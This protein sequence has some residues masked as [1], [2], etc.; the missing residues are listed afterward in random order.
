MFRRVACI[1][2]ASGAV[3]WAQLAEEVPSTPAVEDVFVRDSAAAMDRLALAARMERL[4]EWTTS[5]QVYQ[6]LIEQHGPTLLP[7][8]VDERTRPLIYRSVTREVQRRLAAWPAEGIEVYRSLYGIAAAGALETA[9]SSPSLLARVLDHYFVTDAGLDAGLRLLESAYA[10]GEFVNAAMLG[11]R[12]L[13]HPNLGDRRSMLR[14]RTAATWALAG[15]PERARAQATQLAAESPD[16]SGVVGGERQNLVRW[17]DATLPALDAGLSTPESSWPTAFGSATRSAIGFDAL[18]PDASQAIQ[19]ARLFVAPAVRPSGASASADPN[20]PTAFSSTPGIFPVIEGNELYFQDNHA[21]YAWDLS[22]GQPLPRWLAER[23]GSGDGAQRFGSGEPPRSTPLTLTLTSDA[24]LAVLGQIDPLTGAPNRVTSASASLVCLNRADGTVRWRFSTSDLREG[25]EALRFTAPVGTPMV[26]GDSV[27][28]VTRGGRTRQFDDTFLVCLDAID[29]T[30][31]WSRHLVSGSGSSSLF[32]LTGTPSSAVG[33]QAALADGRVFVTTDL[34]AVAAVD[35]LDGNIAWLSVY[36]RPKPTGS[37]FVRR[38]FGETQRAASSFGTN[39][40]IHSQG[41]I[42]CIPADTRSLFVFDAVDGTRIQDLDL[43]RIDS[44]GSG[45]MLVGVLGSRVLLASETQ[46]VDVDLDR[47]RADGDPADAIRWRHQVLR[48]DGGVAIPARPFVTDRRVYIPT[49]S[50]LRAV[51]HTSGKLVAEYPS[52]TLVRDR[53]VWPGDEWPGNPVVIGSTIV[54]GGVDAVAV[55]LDIPQLRQRLEADIA[56]HPADV[57]PRLRAAST[58]WAMR[59][60]AQAIAQLDE[61]IR[62]AGPEDD[63]A[64]PERLATIAP[65]LHSLVRESLG[66]TSPDRELVRALFDRYERVAFDPGTRAAVRLTRARFELDEDPSST[67]AILSSLLGDPVLASLPLRTSD[68]AELDVARAAQRMVAQLIARH[69]REHVD[70]IE[71]TAV[72]RLDELRAASDPDGAIAVARAHPWLVEAHDA[73]LR[74]IDQ[75]EE[76]GDR[77]LARQLARE[78]LGMVQARPLAGSLER[79][80][81]LS[82]DVDPSLAAEVVSRLLQADPTW[83]S[84]R[85]WEGANGPGRQVLDELERRERGMEEASMIAGDLSRLVLDT[86]VVV[87]VDGMVSMLQPA[88]RGIDAAFGVDRLRRLVVARPDGRVERIRTSAAVAGARAQWIGQQLLLIGADAIALIDPQTASMVWELSLEDLTGAIAEPTI[89]TDDG[90]MVSALAGPAVRRAST[91]LRTQAVASRRPRLMPLPARGV[92]HTI[93]IQ[94]SQVTG[95]LAIVP[96]SRGMVVAVELATGKPSWARQAGERSPT[97]GAAGAG[98]VAF[99]YAGDVPQVMVF[100]ASS[101][102]ITMVEAFGST[103]ATRLGGLAI[104]PRGAMVVLAGDRL[105]GYDLLTPEPMRR[106]ETS[107]P[108]LN[109]IAVNVNPGAQ[110]SL[111]I[112]RGRVCLLWESGPDAQ[113][114]A[115]LD[116]RSGE[117]LVIDAPVRLAAPAAPGPNGSARIRA[118]GSMLYAWSHRGI[119]AYDAA[120]NGRRVWSSPVEIDDNRRIGEEP[121]WTRNHVLTFVRNGIVP[122]QPARQPTLEVFSRRISPSGV[123]S[124][125]IE[126]VIDLSF[127]GAVSGAPVVFETG[128]AWLRPDGRIVMLSTSAGLP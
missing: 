61:A 54:L 31:R 27:L 91:G 85:P 119:I 55:Y 117:P 63:T 24:V 32:E 17:L 110:S 96:T 89:M 36:P 45:W 41:R 62:L 79:L 47:V 37:R 68:G 20:F 21:V 28:I 84:D 43:A 38:G 8:I 114:I 22:T 69:G 65:M 70:A 67:A 122:G 72:A 23:P 107:L 97:A 30:F 33:S 99:A 14:A 125:R 35:T 116:S 73:M 60:N 75:L 7:A 115:I 1:F 39:P 52:R 44:R 109:V 78:A 126:R 108:G 4:R 113:P 98:L 71:K 2:V 3:A 26:A 12:L 81:R 87:Q 9:G 92:G 49:G 29:G 5:A 121:V 11:D 66:R 124:G 53:S 46:V 10:R 102:R 95:G 123:E 128:I 86:P 82:A 56:A 76:Q 42:F 112:V 80:G 106:F 93:D 15:S 6:E 101:G 111:M 74:S 18:E 103:L 104:S 77:T 105:V 120:D 94:R 127:A 34:G 64:R 59:D 51:D 57:A 90:V 25:D 19:V 48:R 58:Y 100:E 88:G 83:R 13:A 16:A 40:T 118:V 50:G